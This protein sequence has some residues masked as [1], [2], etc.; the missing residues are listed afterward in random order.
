MTM[1]P[2]EQASLAKLESK[3]DHVRAAVRGVVKEFHTGLFL[4]GEGGTSKS[5]TVMKELETLRCKYTYH[6]TRMTGRG[7]VDELQRAP[8]DVHF[9]EDAETLLDDRKSWGVLR[10]A[11]WS[12]SKKK[13][14][15]R[16]IT[17]TAF[18]TKI[19]FTFFGGVIVI[20]NQ[21]LADTIPEVR[22]IKSRIMVLHLD[23]SGEEIKALMKQICLNGYEYGDLRLDADECLAV[24]QFVIDRLSELHRPLDLR[25][26]MN[27]FRDYLQFKYGESPLHWHQLM[28]GRMSQRVL[29]MDRRQTNAE[30]QRLALEIRA[31][32]L[33]SKEQERLAKEQIGISPA[34]YYR[35]LKRPA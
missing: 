29:Y 10:S 16:P 9:I 31:M 7:L 18:N 17:W 27:G 22:A 23:F 11:L 24:R 14:M 32:G 34:A 12:Q 4:H 20:S 15:E 1:T 26:M 19:D 2:D 33:S 21:N 8:G 3:L 25:I 5:Y 35:A 13:P 6:N 30:K 28:L